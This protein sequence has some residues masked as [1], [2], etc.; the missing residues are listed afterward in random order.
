MDSENQVPKS[1]SSESEIKKIKYHISLL[2]EI[3]DHRQYPIPN[4]VIS[5]DWD[6]KDLN[7]VHDIFEAFDRKLEDGEDI[8]WRKLESDLKKKFGIGYQAVK[9][10]VLAFYDN[11]QW[12]DV[13]RGYAKA[14]DVMEFKRIN[15][16]PRPVPDD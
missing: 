15:D 8:I 4:L 5:F 3:L 2:Q 7:A 6:E 16:R 9:R 13:C 1:F 10:I 14:N 11:D 12:I